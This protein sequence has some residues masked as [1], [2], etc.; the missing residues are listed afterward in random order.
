MF[1][2]PTDAI[3]SPVKWQF[4]LMYRNDVVVFALSPCDHFL[5]VKRVSSL[6]QNAKVALKLKKCSFFKQIIVYFVHFSRPRRLKIA[7]QTTA[8]IEELRIITNKTE[9]CSFPRIYNVFVTL[10]PALLR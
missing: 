3:L 4:T 8:A 1:L 6:L 7:T 10:R 2:W 9:F 5:Y